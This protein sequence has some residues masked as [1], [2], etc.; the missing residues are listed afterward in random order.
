[1][2]DFRNLMKFRQRAFG[3]AEEPLAFIDEAMQDINGRWYDPG[4]MTYGQCVAY[5]RYLKTE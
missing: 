3:T 1:M 4:W 5:A 2:S